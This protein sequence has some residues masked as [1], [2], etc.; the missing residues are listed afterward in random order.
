MAQE[1]ITPIL[2]HLRS[3]GYIIISFI[4]R[5]ERSEETISRISNGRFQTKQDA[6]RELIMIARQMYRL[7]ET[8][9]D[10]EVAIPAIFGNW[11]P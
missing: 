8:C 1:D 7:I 3:R 4:E 9:E 11:V 6:I 2:E 10:A 5:S